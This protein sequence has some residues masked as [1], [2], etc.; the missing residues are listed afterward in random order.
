MDKKGGNFMESLTKNKKDQKE[1][2]KMVEKFFAPNTLVDYEELTEG[3]FNVAYKIYLSD[4]KQMILK[5][6][7][8]QDMRIM[9]Y[10]K[11]IMHSEIE[12]MKTVACYEK[13][14]APQ[15]LGDDETCTLIN[16]PY[17]FMEV[18]EGNSL[19]TIKDKLSE[20]QLQM[21][22]FEVGQIIHKVNEIQCPCFGY[23]GQKAFQGEKW[24]PIFEKMLEQGIQ[25]AEVGHVDLKISIDELRQLLQRDRSIFDEVTIPKLVHWDCWDGNIF[26]K[27]GKVTGIIDWERCLWADPLMEVNF[28][29]YDDNQWFKKGYGKG[30]LSE[31]EY[32]RA[33]WYDIY[34]LILMSLECE[35]RQYPDMG[36]YDWASGL[37]VKQFE[38]LR[39]SR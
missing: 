15:L 4:G 27:D 6:A 23:P 35:Y 9:S 14:H 28:R 38:K 33:L 1:L 39:A 18:L 17:F 13:I 37:L 16:A 2:E 24:F 25:D 31:K 12:A 20:E 26:V 34:A 8:R 7:P 30:E 19:S 29:T 11:G 10:E 32:L 3:F 36:M 5:I 21:I 22:Y